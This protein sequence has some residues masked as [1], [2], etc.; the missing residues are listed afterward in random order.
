MYRLYSVFTIDCLLIGFRVLYFLLYL[1]L[2]L[3]KE[4]VCRVEGEFPDGEVVCEEPILVVSFKVGLC[5]V[6]PKGK[7]SRTVFQKLS[8]N[9]CSSVVRCL[10]L[11][12]RTH[13]IRVHLQYLGFPILN[14]PIY[15]SSAWGPN[16]GKGGL[17]GKNDQELLEALI[18]EHRSKE[19]LHLLDIT[20]EVV[21]GKSELDAGTSSGALVNNALTVKNESGSTA[22]EESTS[23]DKEAE[24]NITQAAEKDEEL[25]RTAD[26]TKVVRDLLCSECKIVRPDPTAKELVMYLHALRYKG[27]DFEY[28]THLPDWAKED[29]VQN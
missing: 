22:C 8:Y 19:S 29:W 6:D 10:P 24:M 2:Q 23:N 12:G 18:E 21:S 5:R 3:E 4:Y 17:V 11:T 7:D 15:G 26:A 1:L 16:R 27:P 20:D 25:S 13:Q 14:D 28:S 9:G